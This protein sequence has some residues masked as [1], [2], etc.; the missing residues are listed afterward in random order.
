MPAAGGTL[1]GFRAGEPVRAQPALSALRLRLESAGADLFRHLDRD[2]PSFGLQLRHAFESN[3]R[4]LREVYDL[5][6]DRV[7]AQRSRRAERVQRHLQVSARARDGAP[8][9]V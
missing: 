9:L 8:A 3:R 4:A 6:L 7:E 1:Q 5:E 2:G